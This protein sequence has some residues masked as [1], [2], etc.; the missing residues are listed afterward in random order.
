[1][2]DFFHGWRRKAGVAG[3]VMACC[4]A[5]GWIRSCVS[6]DS[7]QINFGDCTYL[8]ITSS[9]HGLSIARFFANGGP[10][11]LT[12]VWRVDHGKFEW[13]FPS[14]PKMI[15]GNAFGYTVC[16]ISYSSIVIP[17][18]LI[19]AYLL[20]VKPRVAKPL[21]MSEPVPAEAP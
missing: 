10:L 3:L 21:K 16:A 15:Q 6:H 17:L 9:I 12:V 5:F 19:S 2:G 8:D 20:L 18:T 14:K 11:E 13:F 1:M 4:W 7:V